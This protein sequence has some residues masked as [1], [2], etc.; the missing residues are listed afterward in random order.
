MKKK[1]LIL[2][3]A[4]IVIA[5][6]MLFVMKICGSG[7]GNQ[8][9]IRVDGKVYGTYD[10]NTDR[11]IEVNIDKNHNLVCI[12]GGKAYMKEA[13]CP[14]GYCMNQGRID[15]GNETIICLPHKLVVEVITGDDNAGTQ[16]IVPD[17]IVK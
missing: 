6:I 2:G 14:D 8:V 16:D 13:D 1:D 5:L 3:A 15:S 10:L 17:V 9:C 4:V 11:E 7:K 12:S